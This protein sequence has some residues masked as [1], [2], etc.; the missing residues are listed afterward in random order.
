MAGRTDHKNW[1]RV[2]RRAVSALL[3]AVGIVVTVVTFTPVTGWYSRWLSGR[4]TDPGGQVLVVLCGSYLE[5]GIIGQDTYWRAVYAV[6]AYRRWKYP[7]V[8]LSGAGVSDGMREFLLSMAVPAG[9]IELESRSH[10]TRE[11][12]LYVR[13][14][15]G[16]S[17]GQAVLMTSDYHM[18]RASR[19][20]ARAGMPTAAYPIPHALKL[21]GHWTTRW[22]AFL[23]EVSES[24]KTVYYA[25]R[26]WI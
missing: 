17:P 1:L 7:R 25:A 9:A 15:L 18:F 12:A 22:T 23:D 10:S 3:L 16:D 4:Y 2:L 5:P 21:S 6:R 11:S 14:M 24:V 20:F 26:G 8:I 19:A 13:Q